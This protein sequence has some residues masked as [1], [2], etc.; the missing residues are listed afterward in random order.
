MRVLILALLL[1]SPLGAL[2]TTGCSTVGEAARGTGDV[3]GD[4]ARGT[5]EVI[6]DTA[7]TAED[8]LDLEEGD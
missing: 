7:E 6:H 4:A 2:T 5:G 8:E 1:L 3:V